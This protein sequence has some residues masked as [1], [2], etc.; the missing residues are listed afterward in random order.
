MLVTDFLA[1]HSHS[2]TFKTNVANMPAG[3]LYKL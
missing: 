2:F 1:P 3:Y